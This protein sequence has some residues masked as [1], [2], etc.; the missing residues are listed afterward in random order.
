MSSKPL[1]SVIIPAYNCAD[2][3]TESVESALAQD[4]PNKEII[5][6][7]DGSTDN[8]LNVLSP[9]AGKIIVIQQQN[10]GSAA[11]R[12][13]GIKAAKG[14]FVAFL[15]SDDL[16]FPGKLSLQLG[17]MISNP[18]IGLVYHAWG[19]WEPDQQGKY[20]PLSIPTLPQDK[21]AIDADKSGWIYEKLFSDSII[22]TTSAMIRR[23]L[24]EKAGLF[25]EELRK[26][27]D[28]EYWFRISRYTQVRKLQAVLS[29]YRINLQSVT[30]QPSAVNYGALVINKVLTRW[31]RTGPDHTM[32]P[33]SVI[34]KRLATI[35]HRFAYLHYKRGNPWIATRAFALTIFNAPF[36]V[37]YWIYMLLSFGKVLRSLLSL[38]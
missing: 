21:F 2:H 14:E 19:V 7:D 11:A 37:R 1:V 35:W 6:I 8:T 26:G 9:F 31:G 20:S 17:Y 33:R 3:I 29:V 27:Q 13:T 25:D 38:T 24:I 36:N 34:R 15:D 4:Y 5:I 28:Y 12:N 23:E 16:W 22:H 30:N 18:S 32:I 10:A